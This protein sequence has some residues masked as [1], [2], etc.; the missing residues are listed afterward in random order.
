MLAIALKLSVLNILA[1]LLWFVV[2]AWLIITVLTLY[3]LSRQK[4]LSPIDDLRLQAND[5]PLVSVLVPARNEEHRVLADCIHSILD[6]DYGRLEIIAVNDHSTDATGAILELLARADARLRVI[7]GKEPPPGWLGKAYAMHQA[8]NHARGEWIL[9]TDADMIFEKTALRTA[10]ANTLEREADAMTL[11]PYFEASSFWE[12]VM[13]PTWAWALLMFTVLYRV[14]NPKSKG[15]V[16]IGGFF[17]MR[18][19]TLEHAGGYE[20]LKDEVLE[21][22]R[23]AE[24]IKRY[25]GSLFTE[26]APRLLSTR[27]YR[28]FSEMWECCTKNWF[29]GVKFSLPFAMWNVFSIYLIAV[30]PPLIALAS[31]ISIATGA[32]TNLWRLFVPAALSWLMQ[33]LV[34]VRVSIRSEVFPAYALTA[35]L[36]LGVLYAMLFDSSIRITLGKGVRWKGRRVYENAGVR[37]PQLRTVASRLSKTRK[38][39][40]GMLS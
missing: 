39:E 26:Y 4:T 8:F 36:G 40:E 16:G 35:P 14:N 24:M 30:V 11:I 23:L 38:K 15:A 19:G 10:V 2:L 5:A 9:A 17:L 21:D 28:N 12:H 1:S 29:S 32:S 25:G 7:E 33:V 37:P 31:A 18:R 13:I 20:A 6:Q 22:V 27:M 3:G 34:L